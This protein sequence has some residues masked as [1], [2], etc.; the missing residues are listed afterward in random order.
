MRTEFDTSFNAGDDD[1]EPD[2]KDLRTRSDFTI[3]ATA[4]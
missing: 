3:N 1:S 2:K 4:D